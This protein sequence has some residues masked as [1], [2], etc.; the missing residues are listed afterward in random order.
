[1]YE[2][3]RERLQNTFIDLVKI[4][5]PSW[6]EKPV[7]EYLT[8]IFD[9]LG[10]AWSLHPCGQSHNLLAGIEGEPGRRKL[11][12][13]VIWIPW[14]HVRTSFPIVKGDRITPTATR[15]S[16]GTTRRRSRRSSRP[17]A[18][19]GNGGTAR[20]ARIPLFV[21]GGDRA[22]RHQGIRPF[23]YPRDY[24][25]VFDSGGDIGG[26]VLEARHS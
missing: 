22:L 2:I 18:S 12:S 7:I 10:V 11:L 21:R 23:A 15:S 26:I 20:P 3:N 17:C 9:E 5:S 19:S 4:P 24:A 16:A 25:F 13:H 1:M 14:F 6:K 8:S